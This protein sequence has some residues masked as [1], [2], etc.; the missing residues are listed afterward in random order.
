VDLRRTNKKV[1]ESLIKCGAMDALGPSRKSMAEQLDTIVEEASSFQKEKSNGQFNLFAGECEVAVPAADSSTHDAEEWD[2]LYKLQLEKELMGFYVTGHP[3]MNFI[4]IIEKY[5]NASSQT[6]A[7]TEPQSLVR[8]A[9]MI[10]KI[11]EINTKKGDRMAFISL[12]DLTGITEVTV[13]ADLYK[14]TRDLLQSG[15]PLM[16]TGVR[17]GDKESPKMLAHEIYPLD[18]TPR[19]M[20]KGIRIRISALGADPRH[21]GQLKKIFSKHRGRVPVKVSVSIPNRSETLIS[22]PAV[23][24]DPSEE[25]ITEI[26]DVLGYP[27]VTL[28]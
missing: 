5:S 9:G 27:A 4:D 2:D 14:L 13:F 28:E 10:K 7:A 18:E 15:D 1:I 25:F 19:R 16:I 17:E 26:R 24:C 23:E 12:E 8:M 11:K 21:V 22:L 6:L 3:L 20:S